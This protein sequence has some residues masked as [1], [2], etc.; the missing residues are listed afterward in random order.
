MNYRGGYKYQLT[1][2]ESFKVGFHVPENIETDYIDLTRDGYLFIERGY[3]WDGPSGPA[4]D[5][6]NFMRGSLA[7]DALYQLIRTGHLSKTFRKDSDLLLKKIC[8]EDGMS[9]VR[10]QWVYLGV[11]AGGVGALKPTIELSAP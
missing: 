5:T 9:K 2:P 3:A 1:T 7:H 6:K 4:I 11:R 10:A 8:L